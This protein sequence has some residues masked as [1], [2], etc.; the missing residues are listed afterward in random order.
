MLSVSR[1]LA[2]RFGLTAVP[3]NNRKFITADPSDNI[4]LTA[5][6]PHQNSSLFQNLIS[7][8]M[9]ISII[10]MLEVI[11]IKN[12][13][14]HLLIRS[15]ARS[16][17]CLENSQIYRLFFSPVKSSSVANFS[18]ILIFFSI[19]VSKETGGIVPAS[20]LPWASIRMS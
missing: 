6:P 5:A 18:S 11:N 7:G 13:Q 9:A 19:V 2:R 12:K 3:E 16:I 17:I 8:K 15:L 14:C 1:L 4:V 20:V 10:V